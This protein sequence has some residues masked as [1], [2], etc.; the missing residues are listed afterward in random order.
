MKYPEQLKILR[1]FCKELGGELIFAGPDY[2]DEFSISPFCSCCGLDWEK[3]QIVL[4][5]HHRCTDL[6]HVIHE[7]AHVFATKWNPHQLD[8]L[9]SEEDFFYW[10]SL[11]AEMIGISRNE[12][13]KSMPDYLVSY[14]H[15]DLE[16]ERLTKKDLENYFRLRLE[17]GEYR[18]NIIDSKPVAVR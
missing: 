15:H 18:G 17:D 12:W 16:I 4:N 1:Q 8:L 13:V 5:R 11:V 7:M 3:K 2:E 6:G 9:G 10:E 14:Q